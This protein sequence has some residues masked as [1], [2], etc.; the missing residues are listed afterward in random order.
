MS[1][2]SD[3]ADWLS[4]V[5]LLKP[6]ADE[7][8]EAIARL[9]GF[10]LRGTG[11]AVAAAPRRMPATAQPLEESGPP[12]TDQP[13]PES[14]PRRRLES[15]LIPGNASRNPAPQWLAT[16]RHL[17]TTDAAHLRPA[18][19]L[20][21]LFPNHTSRAILSGALATPSGVG[22]L[23]MAKLIELLSRAEL[24]RE[25]PRFSIP[26]LVRGVQ[27]LIDR[28]EAMQPFAAD[29]ATLRAALASVVGR[30]RTAVLYFDSSPVWGAGTGPKDEWPDYKTPAP[31]T[32]V[33]VL[34]DL[35]I[36]HPPG[37][38]GLAG[39]SDWCEFAQTLARAGCP[40]LALVPYPRE[41]WPAPLAKIM[42]IVQWDRSTTAAVVRRAVR[43][44]LRVVKEI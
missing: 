28:G 39:V 16:A 24:I 3:L 15:V 6:A 32:P 30:D 20:E 5:D 26:T 21:P 40:L 2:R 12:M 42:T 13:G 29:Q 17:E 44:G 41:R 27:L 31:G 11:E 1:E 36:A 19:P 22:P 4:A 23:H 14:K 38:A 37:V 8:L 35:G 43:A 9:L 7:G 10:R 25:I 34:T 33:V 18:I